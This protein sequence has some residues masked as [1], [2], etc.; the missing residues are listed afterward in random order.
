MGN[1]EGSILAVCRPNVRQ[2]L[3]GVGG[4]YSNAVFRLFTACSV[5]PLSLEVVEKRATV[6]SF[7]YPI[8]GVD[9]RKFLQ[10]FRAIRQSLIEFRSLTL[11]CEALPWNRMQNWRRVGRNPGS[12]FWHV[13]KFMKY[14]GNAEDSMWFA[15]RFLIVYVVFHSVDICR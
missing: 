10:H 9:D 8:F 1:Y 13:A 12:I 2:I 3:T 4:P 6:N 11:V 7:W 5:L 14:W 15:T